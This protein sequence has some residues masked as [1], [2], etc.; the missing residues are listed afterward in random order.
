M[1]SQAQT[2][3]C[4]AAVGASV[5]TFYNAGTAHTQCKIVNAVI[6]STTCCRS[7]GTVTCNVPDR[8]EAALKHVGNW[9]TT[10]SGAEPW[11][12]IDGELTAGH[13]VGVLIRLLG[14]SGHFLAI[15][16]NGTSGNQLIT[17]EDPSY[18]GRSTVI[19]SSLASSAHG[20]WQETYFTQP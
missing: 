16:G 8:L 14:G 10:S 9:Q 15:V 19:H 20:V 1:Q 2:C 17:T 6:S 18:H 7:G 5:A 13:P 12:S 3:W 11:S 4:W